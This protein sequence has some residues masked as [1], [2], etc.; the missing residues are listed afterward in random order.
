LLTQQS[1]Q[2]RC[3]GLCQHAAAAAGIVVCAQSRSSTHPTVPP[4][5][6]PGPAPAAG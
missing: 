2:R 4:V 1:S 5:V 6:M 3:Q